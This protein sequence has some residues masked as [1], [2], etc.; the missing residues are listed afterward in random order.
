MPQSVV[1]GPT[2]PADTAIHSGRLPGYENAPVNTTPEYFW[3]L[4]NGSLSAAAD[5]SIAVMLEN[6]PG[7][8]CSMR[9]R[10]T[11]A[12]DTILLTTPIIGAG[13]H[14]LYAYPEVLPQPGS[15]PLTVTIQVY[16]TGQDPAAEEP[17]ATYTEQ[18]QLTIPK[19]AALTQ[20]EAESSPPA[21]A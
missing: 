4:Y 12:D 6:T 2:P 15:Y 9:V 7:N 11:M 1:P 20:K 5:G 14:L 3:Y 18:A 10:Y 17:F 19:G 8:E 13:E 21:A 16:H